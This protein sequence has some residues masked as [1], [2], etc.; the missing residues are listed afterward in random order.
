MLTVA[1][2]LSHGWRRALMTVAGATLGVG[3]QLAITLAG[4]ASF[5]LVL[6]QGFEW[7][8]WAGIAYLIYLG[9]RHWRAKPVEAANRSGRSLFIQGLVVTIPNPKSLLFLVAFFPQF[10]D[11]HTPLAQQISIMA[12]TFL[13]ITFVF[14]G[15][16]A[17]A[18]D[19]VGRYFQSGRGARI[20]NRI[21]GGLMIGAGLGLALARRG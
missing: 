6:A 18:A 1:H 20:G 4:M 7:L 15:L 12:P 16:W 2:A 13:A 14:T 8:R 9:V 19:R 5:M 17:V 3:V 11:P 21:S 10:I